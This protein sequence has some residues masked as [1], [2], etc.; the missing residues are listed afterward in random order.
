MSG[1][2][3]IIPDPLTKNNP[4]K[5]GE[6]PDSVTLA[7][8]PRFDNVRR[9]VRGLQI[10]DETFGTLEIKTRDGKNLLLLDSG[11]KIDK[12]DISFSPRY[13]NFL[14][15]S[16]SES[17]MEKVQIVET[18]GQAFA[19]YFGNRPRTLQVSGI[20]L[21]SADFN[22]KNEFWYNY[23][24]YLRGT[25]LVVNDTV[26]YLSY[27]DVTVIGFLNNAATD[28]SSDP[29]E[30]VSFNFSMLVSS[31]IPTN[32][33]G[34]N[35]PLYRTPVDIEPDLITLPQSEA[36]TNAADADKSYTRFIEGALNGSQSLDFLFGQ[37]AQ[38]YS[39][40]GM[41]YITGANIKTPTGYDGVVLFDGQPVK[42]KYGSSITQYQANKVTYGKFRDNTDEYIAQIKSNSS[43]SAVY[44]KA[45]DVLK[46]QTK[47][48]QDTQ[49]IAREQFK[50]Y[51]VNP[52]PPN[53]YSRLARVGAFA[54]VQ[55]AGA[56]ILPRFANSDSNATSNIEASVTSQVSSRSNR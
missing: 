39:N 52:D 24:N 19:F 18:F 54:T 38:N 13:S 17:S 45:D 4:D 1:F 30:Y 46:A 35:K 32:I 23:N 44:V 55:V 34:L 56:Q 25:Q 40:F 42:Y 43:A 27:D 22:W 7:N 20:L 47:S 36:P 3:Q 9:P 11:G 31:V 51:N 10:K 33:V 21:N 15:Q 2:V 14:L 49:K 53:Q 26:A 41:Q 50:K 8:L 6:K 16:V 28:Q 12:G 29:Q 37:N 48:A 5:T